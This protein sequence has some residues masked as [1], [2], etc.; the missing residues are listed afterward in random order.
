MDIA[1]IIMLLAVLVVNVLSSIRI[2]RRVSLSRTQRLVQ[3]AIV[4]CVP[5][6]G[7]IVCLAVISIDAV[8]EE[9]VP[10]T[11][12]FVESGAAGAIEWDAPPGGSLCGCGGSDAGGDGGD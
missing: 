2:A 11:T 1:W 6:V 10:D 12:S 3:F 4:W 9:A 7:A 8:L 5:I